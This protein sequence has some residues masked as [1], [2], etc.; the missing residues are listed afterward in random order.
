MGL[1]KNFF[2]RS[3]GKCYDTHCIRNFNQIGRR[4]YCYI[5]KI[6][7]PAPKKEFDSF[8]KFVHY[9]NIYKLSFFFEKN[10][11]LQLIFQALRSLFWKDQLIFLRFNF[12]RFYF[13][14]YILS[15][16]SSPEQFFQARRNQFGHE[17]PK[18]FRSKFGDVF[19]FMKFFPRTYSPKKL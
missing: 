5:K 14:I 15:E 12:G 7:G 6:S 19:S 3:S 13:Y 17:L 16:L 9:W 4:I 8:F 10:V 11:S 1:K 18:I 2:W